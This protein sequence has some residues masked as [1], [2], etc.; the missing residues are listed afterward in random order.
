MNLLFANAMS[1][2]NVRWCK[3]TYGD[4]RRFEEMINVARARSGVT[5]RVKKCE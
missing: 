2:K 5:P 4:V 1:C 3:E